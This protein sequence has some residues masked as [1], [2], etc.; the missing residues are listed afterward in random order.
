MISDPCFQVLFCDDI[1]CF[2]PV[3]ADKIDA[4]NY[5][6]ISVFRVVYMLTTRRFTDLKFPVHDLFLA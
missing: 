1:K 2:N 4:S 3:V 6:G 5:A